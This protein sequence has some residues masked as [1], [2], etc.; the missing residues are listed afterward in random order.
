MRHRLD[1]TWLGGKTWVILVGATQANR[2]S[3]EIVAIL[4]TTL[5]VQ[6]S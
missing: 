6:A 1:G 4:T 2:P 5:M 3:R